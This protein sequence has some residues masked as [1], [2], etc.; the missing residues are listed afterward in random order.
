MTTRTIVAVLLGL[1]CSIGVYCHG[2]SS[3]KPLKVRAIYP[4]GEEVATS[5]RITI[6]FNQNMVSLGASMFVE[7]V[8]LIDIEPAVECEWNWVKLNTLQCEL[9]VDNDLKGSTK[10]TVT[11]RSGIK[12][13]NGQEIAESLVHSFE[14][15]VPSIT[16]AGLVS[17]KSSTQ[18]IVQVSFNQS[19]NI[20]S[21]QDRLFLYD[22]SSGK[23]IPVKI[24]PSDWRLRS[25][26][27]KDYFGRERTYQR[28]DHSDCDITGL[29]G[30]E[31]LVLPVEQL[32]PKSKA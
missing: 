26:F 1:V 25:T 32:S 24:C 15:I 31:V 9:P 4:A 23:E 20:E 30:S 22:T 11:I 12:A 29:N 6:E 8:V 16:L 18:P 13:P 19:V 7:D 2:N 17:W 3:S 14:T 21:L 27:R 5:D 10:Y 28:F